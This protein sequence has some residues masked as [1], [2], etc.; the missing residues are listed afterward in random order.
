M[1]LLAGVTASGLLSFWPDFFALW[2]HDAISYDPALTMTLLI[3]TAF[4]VLI[5]NRVATEY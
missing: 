2:T 3:G 1:T 5:R 4:A